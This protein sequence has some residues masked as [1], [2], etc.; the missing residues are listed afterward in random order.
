MNMWQ[1]KVWEWCG[2][3]GD[4]VCDTDKWDYIDDRKEK[5]RPPCV[6]STQDVDQHT[7]TYGGIK[8]QVS[9]TSWQVEKLTLSLHF[10][11][12]AVCVKNVESREYHDPSHFW[13]LFFPLY[14]NIKFL[15]ASVQYC[16][17]NF[18]AIRR[19]KIYVV[20][21][22]VHTYYKCFMIRLQLGH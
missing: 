20:N 4:V 3:C 5:L 7:P 15:I 8:I 12:C 13:L 18:T 10:C 9:V 2:E 16:W 6:N 11:D 22:H 19:Y 21:E 17:W 1:S 14:T